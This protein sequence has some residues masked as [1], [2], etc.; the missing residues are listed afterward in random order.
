MA[1][2]SSQS[3]LVLIF[4][5]SVDIMPC[6]LC[7]NTHLDFTS[8]MHGGFVI[9]CDCGLQF[10]KFELTEREFVNQWNTRRKKT[11]GIRHGEEKEG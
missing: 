9:A 1:I 6:P 11:W 4:G 2:H 5:V 7:Y 8:L 3:N 10:R